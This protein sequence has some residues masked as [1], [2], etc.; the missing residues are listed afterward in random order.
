MNRAFLYITFLTICFFLTAT[1]SYGQLLQDRN[2]LKTEVGPRKNFSNDKVK[3]PSKKSKATKA[4]KVFPKYSAPNTGKNENHNVKLSD[5][6]SK[7][8]RKSDLKVKTINPKYSKEATFSNTKFF[9]NP[10]YTPANAMERRNFNVNLKARHPEESQWKATNRIYIVAPRFSKNATYS[11]TKFKVNPRF[12]PAN[13][14]ERRNFNVNLKARHP[15]E[16]QWKATNKIYIVTPRYS[17]EATYTNMKFKPR[18]HSVSTTYTKDRFKIKP[19]T[20]APTY[21][22][23]KFKP[24]NRSV[25]TTYTKDK[26][27]IEPRTVA[28]TYTH[29]KFKPLNRSVSTTYTNDKFKIKPR[30][31]APTYTDTKYRV[32]TRKSSVPTYTKIKY[33]IEPRSESYTYTN[34]KFK[35]EP[36]TTSFT[37][38]NT[39]Y[40]INPRFSKEST[41]TKTRY[42]VNPR[43]SEPPS[44]IK[45]PAGKKDGHLMFDNSRRHWPMH[46]SPFAPEWEGWKTRKPKKPKDAHPSANYIAAKHATPAIRNVRRKTSITWVR[47]FG[48]KTQPNGVKKQP[49]KVKFDKDEAEIWNNKEREYTR[50]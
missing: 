4:I 43:F 35:I 6:Y 39:K 40:K 7:P 31:I 42:Y 19:R 34:E 50:N 48:N 10:R 9:T 1:V 41:Y 21:T 25:S 16:S 30:S 22:H 24:L 11:N 32:R 12:T 33:K 18:N 29:M 28:P 49:K 2:K 15:E 26:F 27:K 17:K 8:T 20:I 44:Y 5:K 38:T 46:Y 36:R 13:A 3:E 23:M 47:V 37:Y 14:M 45:F